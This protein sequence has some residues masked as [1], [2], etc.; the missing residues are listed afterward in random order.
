M[1]ACTER[2]QKILAH[3]GAAPSRRKAETLI[4]E[5]R[6]TVNGTVAQVG[7]SADPARDHI[8]LDGKR[9]EMPSTHRYLLL[10]KPPGVMSTRSDPEGRPTVMDLLPPGLRA[11]VVPVG[12]LDYASEGLLLLTDDGDLAHRI[13]HPRYGCGKTYEVKVRGEPERKDLER[14]RTGIRLQGRRTAPAKITPSPAPRG[15]R[16]ASQSSWWVVELHEGRTRQIREMFV[17]IGHPVQRLRRV[18][19]GPLRDSK[20]PS[21][22]VRELSAEEVDRLRQ[23]TG[24]GASRRGPVGRSGSSPKPRR[25]PRADSG[26]G[27]RPKRPGP[28]GGRSPAGDGRTAGGSRTGKAGSRRKGKSGEKRGGKRGTR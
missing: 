22:R 27:P 17:R 16:A 20:L 13:A 9:V 1:S 24:T 19:I 11:A 8:K 25:P 18:A 2:L 10:N 21:G 28:R 7:D 6:V 15:P 26:S 4:R 3:A 12:R 14:L 23:A 5:G